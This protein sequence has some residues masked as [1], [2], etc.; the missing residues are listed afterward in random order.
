MKNSSIKKIADACIEASRNVSQ[1][2]DV[3]SFLLEQGFFD[4]NKIPE[5]LLNR[6]KQLSGKNSIDVMNEFKK[7]QIKGD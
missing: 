3:S 6:N 7:Q 4:N 5:G 2:G 1:E